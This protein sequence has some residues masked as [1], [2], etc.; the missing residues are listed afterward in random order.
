MKPEFVRKLTLDRKPR[1][2]TVAAPGL[3]RHFLAL[4]VLLGLT[5]VATA[6]PITTWHAITD[7]AKTAE[8]HIARHIDVADGRTTVQ[9]R[10][11]DD[12]LRLAQCSTPL[13]GFL[14]SGTRISAK[15]IVGVRCTGARPWKVYVPVETVVE[16]TVWVARQPL[17]R[18]HILTAADLVADVRD[19]SQMTRSYVS[20]Q[21][22]LLGQRLKLSI[23][24]G[25]VISLELVEADSVIRRG[26]TVTLAVA[27]DAMSIQMAGKALSDGA[28]NQRIRVENLNS[29]RIVEGIV[30]SRELVEVL[31]R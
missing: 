22:T 29:G 18:G 30:R 5:T 20:E 24:A 14:R 1:R 11:L 25:R 26:Q 7:I 12:R 8:A 15:T 31:V 21:K 9:A 19:V 2:D 16:R 23:L 17:P 4:L 28:L 13:E 27:T 3:Q 10:M 6:E